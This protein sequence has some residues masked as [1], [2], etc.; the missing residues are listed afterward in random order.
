M[1]RSLPGAIGLFAADALS[2]SVL[3]DPAPAS[4]A[5]QGR[6]WQHTQPGTGVAT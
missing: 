1:K 6:T 2:A 3:I 4:T 5:A